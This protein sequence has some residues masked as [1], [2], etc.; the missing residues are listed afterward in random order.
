MKLLLCIVFSW[1]DFNE[2]TEVPTD[3]LKDLKNLEYLYVFTFSILFLFKKM[4]ARFLSE[5]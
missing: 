3:A 4:R 1:L 5:H 2:L